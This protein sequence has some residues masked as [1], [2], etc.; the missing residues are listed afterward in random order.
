MLLGEEALIGRT[1]VSRVVEVGVLPHRD[2]PTLNR[3][4]TH[5]LT[6]SGGGSDLLALIEHIVKSEDSIQ[7]HPLEGTEVSTQACAEA[8][9]LRPASE[10]PREVAVLAPWVGEEL[11]RALRLIGIELVDQLLGA[12][13]TAIRAIRLS[14]ASREAERHE[15]KATLPVEAIGQSEAL[16]IVALQLPTLAGEVARDVVGHILAPTTQAEVVALI[17]IG[18]NEVMPPVRMDLTQ[19]I[20]LPAPIGQILL[21]RPRRGDTECRLI[22]LTKVAER[23]RRDEVRRE[24]VARRSGHLHTSLQLELLVS[25]HHRRSLTTT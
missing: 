5:H 17:G 2:H 12:E 6:I 18:T 14:I 11:C 13:V 3:T 8:D 21:S 22:A 10:L 15:A 24:E 20:K 9:L 4:A 25:I 19:G 7:L 16:G 1:K 23:R